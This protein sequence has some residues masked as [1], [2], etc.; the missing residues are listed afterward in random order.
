MKSKSCL[1][2]MLSLQLKAHFPL[3][4]CVFDYQGAD[5][6]V[7]CHYPARLKKEGQRHLEPSIIDSARLNE[8]CVASRASCALRRRADDE[9]LQCFI[10]HSGFGAQLS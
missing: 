1:E 7:S 5:S 9:V 10:R 2:N 3:A 8:G 6:V 4:Q